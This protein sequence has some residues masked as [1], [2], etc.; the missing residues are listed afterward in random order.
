MNAEQ[1]E[2]VDDTIAGILGNDHT[3]L[4]DVM[5]ELIKTEG[6]Y[7]VLAK[8][9]LKPQFVLR[10][11]EH[12]AFESVT[13]VHARHGTDASPILIG[14]DDGL[15]SIQIDARPCADDFDYVEDAAPTPMAEPTRVDLDDSSLAES[16]DLVELK[17]KGESVAA[18]ELESL[19]PN[20]GEGSSS[21][22]LR[23]C[24]FTQS[25]LEEMIVEEPEA[26]KKGDVL[27]LVEV[28][29]PAEIEIASPAHKK[30]QELGKPKS[31]LFNPPAKLFGDNEATP[32]SFNA[33]AAG[34]RF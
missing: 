13:H 8:H 18:E 20:L 15:S 14:A 4:A 28:I 34:S 23:P 1:K 2:L 7:R 10:Y 32:I 22:E 16:G 29:K 19:G 11:I 27:E 5:F 24:G 9:R 30:G 17:P 25:K 31:A 21:M 12:L 3:R 26:E 33:P 6:H